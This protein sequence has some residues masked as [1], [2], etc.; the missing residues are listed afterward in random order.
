MTSH[1]GR[2]YL[3]K[4]MSVNAALSSSKPMSR[5]T[6]DEVRETIADELGVEKEDITLLKPYKQYLEYDSWH[7]TGA[8]YNKTDF[9]KV[10]FNMND[11]K[12]SDR[13]KEQVEEQERYENRTEKEK[14]QDKINTIN[15]YI[16]QLSKELEEVKSF[17][18]DYKIVSDDYDWRMHKKISLMFNDVSGDMDKVISSTKYKDTESKEDII[19]RIIKEHEID[20]KLYKDK[21]EKQISD[22]QQQV[23]DLQILTR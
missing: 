7:H 2:G 9:Y 12:L 21:L 17:G 8:L 20:I 19:N 3:G 16:K 15:S 1:I 14:I 23:E 4:S 10:V 22:L 13:A 6:R 18:N 11:I 5:W